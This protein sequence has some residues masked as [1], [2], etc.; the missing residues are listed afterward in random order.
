MIEVYCSEI[1]KC[2]FIAVSHLVNGKLICAY[3][4]NTGNNCCA[5]C[6]SRCAIADRHPE[7]NA[8]MKFKIICFIAKHKDGNQLSERI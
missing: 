8:I 7:F 3:R 5:L 2:G 4:C 1:F 6:N